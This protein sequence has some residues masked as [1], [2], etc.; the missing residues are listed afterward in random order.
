MNFISTL[1][2]SLI[3]RLYGLCIWLA[4]PFDAKAKQWIDG[5]KNWQEKARAIK[6]RG[7]K[8]IWFHCAS[9]GEFE[10]ARPVIEKWG[11][12]HRNDN[13]ILTFFSP[14]GYEV[15]KNYE[16]ADAVLYL[17]L[18]TATNAKQFIDLIKPDVAL[19][20]KY[21]FWYNYLHELKKRKIPCI[22]FS[23]LFRPEQVFFKWYGGFFRAMLKMFTT[24]F[25][26]N[27]ESKQLLQSI[28]VNSIINYDTRFDRVNEI[29]Q[30]WK[31]SP[32]IEK[33][34]G[35]SPVFIAGSTWPKDEEVILRLISENT[36]PGYKFIIAPHQ[37]GARNISALKNATGAR[38]T[39]LSA[40]T[41]DNTPVTDILIVDNVGRLASLYGY[42]NIAYVG[43]GFD[44]SVHNVLEAAV[45]GLPV[46]FGPNHQK[47]LEAMELKNQGAG[48]SIN[49]L[50]E[51]IKILQNLAANRSPRYLRACK[52]AEAYV[53][54]RLGGSGVII[55]E[56][57]KYTG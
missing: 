55:S 57:G 5:R 51:L 18:D 56:L 10:Q 46:I 19:F 12:D 44:A 38:S 50:H 49:N 48:F 40:L 9:L 8:R 31:P 45:Y 21:E 23:A 7:G 24:V 35:A 36:L 37:V 30:K 22:L 47:S 13:I 20:V 52:N 15:R 29:R 41:G 28:G 17:P 14:S 25:V 34:K 53:Q 33:F 54:Q 32:A 27:E 1:L 4:S 3:I 43:G 6:N 39:L 42:A 11:C 2:Y 16:C 26:Q